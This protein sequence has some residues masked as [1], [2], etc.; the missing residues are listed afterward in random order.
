MGDNVMT[1]VHHFLPFVKGSVPS[2][3]R[4][5]GAWQRLE[6]PSRAPPL[7]PLMVR[8]LAGLCMI[9][10]LQDVAVI[11][12]L[13]FHCMLRTGEVLSL[14]TQAFTFDSR[15]GFAVVDL[16]WSKT[17]KRQ[18]SGE[19]VTIDDPSLCAM[20]KRF[21]IGSKPGDLLLKR[22]QALFKVVFAEMSIFWLVRVWLQAL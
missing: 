20:L 2:A 10:G 19:I 6:L 18:A 7:S 5:L 17:G 15:S 3:W 22:S 8:G 21:L 11:L 13:A 14:V 4:L 9:L 12:L 16:G 1:A